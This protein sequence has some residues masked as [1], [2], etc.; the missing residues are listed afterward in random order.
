MTPN[1][2]AQATATICPMAREHLEGVA[3]IEAAC[4]SEPWSL[5]AFA[6][7]LD[8]PQA[9]Y[10]VAL[11]EG[12]VAGFAGMRVLFGE[13]GITNVAVAEPF[14]RMGLGSRLVEALTGYGC[15]NRLDSITLEVRAGNQGAIA[16][17]TRQGFV[18]VGRRKNFYRF[19]VE[20]AILMTWTCPQG[21]A[22]T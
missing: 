4:F 17:Y 22:N 13:G 3:A 6:G 20:D 9:V 2:D 15:R 1:R 18:P 12:Q 8:N 21:E 14:R 19:P 5:S 10:F 16:L 7:E 11:A